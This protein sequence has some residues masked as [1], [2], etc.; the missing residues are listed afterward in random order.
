MF[1]ITFIV[2]IVYCLSYDFVIMSYLLYKLYTMYNMFEVMFTK[3]K[4]NASYHAHSL[5]MI[6]KNIVGLEVQSVDHFSFSSEK[7]VFV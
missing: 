1:S 7:W 6:F 4:K 2:F 5:M 3:M